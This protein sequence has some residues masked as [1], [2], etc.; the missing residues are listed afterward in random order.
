VKPAFQK[1]EEF[2][3][4][5]NY[6]GRATAVAAGQTVGPYVE[7]DPIKG[8][9][10]SEA[11]ALAIPGVQKF[12]FR[13]ETLVTFPNAFFGKSEVVGGVTVGVL[14]TMTMPLNKVPVINLTPGLPG[15]TNLPGL[16]Y[17]WPAPLRALTGVQRIERVQMSYQVH[18]LD[19]VPE[20]ALTPGEQVILSTC[21]RIAAKVGA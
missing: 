18:N 4:A 12:T 3:L 20:V 8:W 9:R 11:E 14:E 16:G 15:E 21:Q 13:G 6:D 10:L 19:V 7:T 17:S 1:L 5:V 2:Q